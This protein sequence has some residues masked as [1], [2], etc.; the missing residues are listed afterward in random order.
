MTVTQPP[1]L[2]SR[3]AD[4]WLAMSPFARALTLALALPLLILNGWAVAALFGYFRSILVAVIIASLV[5]FLLN[6][7]ISWLQGR[8]FNRGIAAILVFLGALFLFIVVA[9]TVVPLAIAQAQQFASK[10]PEWFESGKSQ[11]VQLDQFLET[12][13][14][15]FNLDA[16]IAQASERL[17]TEL[18]TLVGEA[19]DLT[20]DLAAFTA[21]K[22]IEIILTL[23]LTFYLLLNGPEV[24][25]SLIYWLPQDLQEPFSKT[26][27]RSF[28]GYFTGQLIVATTLGTILSVVYGL[29]KIPFGLLFGL[30]IGLFAIIPFASAVGTALVTILAALRDIGLAVQILVIAVV[31]EQLVENGIAPRVL[32]SVTGLNPFW[33]LLSVLTGARIGGLLGVVLAVPSAVI[34]KAGIQALR[35]STS[36]DENSDDESGQNGAMSTAVPSP[37]EMM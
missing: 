28:R 27:R 1:T 36:D 13:N 10:L 22:V 14:V 35:P 18:E 4:W 20:L 32:G 19:L 34:L 31:V 2:K 3:I 25:N 33:V 21:N 6:Y 7:P 11:I 26:L 12:V 5:S 37:Q 9:I 23:I 29:L 24:W 17:Q 16:V 8:G 15:P 30:T